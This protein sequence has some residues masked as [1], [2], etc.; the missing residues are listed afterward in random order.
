MPIRML[1]SQ[2]L[3]MGDKAPFR[4]SVHRHTIPLVLSLEAIGFILI[5]ILIG[6]NEYLDLPH[7][8]FS[9]PPHSRRVSEVV[10]EGGLIVILG[11]TVIVAS[12]RT[13]RRLAYL[14]SL[15]TLCGSCQDIS[16]DGRW[17]PFEAFIAEQD[18]IQTSHGLCPTCFEKELVAE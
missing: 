3:E 2:T 11:V 5:V 8:L 18:R 15:L 13:L 12:W 10:L 17:I 7:R 14:E 6:L 4:F 16:L 1:M 9:A